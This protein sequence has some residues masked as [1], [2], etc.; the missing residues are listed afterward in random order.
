M[1]IENHLGRT[2]VKMTQNGRSG[3]AHSK[4]EFL[5]RTCAVLFPEVKIGGR[6]NRFRFN[7]V[8]LMYP[9]CRSE[10]GRVADLGI[11]MQ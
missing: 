2:A 5:E 7:D 4:R 3:E 10:C 9:L 1:S 11:G 6:S 8:V